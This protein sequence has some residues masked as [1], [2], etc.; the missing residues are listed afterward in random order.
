[1]LWFFFWVIIKDEGIF[2]FVRNIKRYV[3]HQI[4]LAIKMN[5]GT[6]QTELDVKLKKILIFE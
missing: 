2:K 3:Y 6:T 4:T 1:M 5:E